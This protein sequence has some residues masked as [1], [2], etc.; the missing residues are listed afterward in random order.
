MP[1]TNDFQ[2]LSALNAS[3][4]DKPLATTAAFGPADPR[5]NVLAGT[6]YS[7][8]KPQLE[9]KCLTWNSWIV[10][11]GMQA[12]LIFGITVFLSSDHPASMFLAIWSFFF[13]QIFAAVIG[14]TILG[15]QRKPVI[16]ALVS[17]AFLGVASL[18]ARE[19]ARDISWFPVAS[20]FAMII[21]NGLFVS[22]SRTLTVE[23]QKILLQIRGYKV[24]LQETELDLLKE[25]GQ[26]P[27]SMPKLASLP[28]AIALDLQEPSGDDLANT[29]ASA[30]TSVSKTRS[31]DPSLASRQSQ[32]STRCEH[33]RIK[34]R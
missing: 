12:T 24:F 14:R 30:T 17:L 32:S 20:Y 22:L 13:L 6:I 10:F 26:T 15:R 8:V 1:Q 28:Y 4:S 19:I 33:R 23:G 21:V 34:K 9:G 29:F 5:I 25:L 16:A 3:T 2:D 18:A 7:Q 11:L 31:V 27:S